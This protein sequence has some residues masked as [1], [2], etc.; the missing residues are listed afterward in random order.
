MNGEVARGGI[1]IFLGKKLLHEG[2]MNIGK[3][4]DLHKDADGFLYLNYSETNP[5]WSFTIASKSSIL[6]KNSQY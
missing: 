4:Y 1:F 5:F 2:Q 3:L 6:S